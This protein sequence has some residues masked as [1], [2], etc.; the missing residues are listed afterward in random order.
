M[1]TKELTDEQYIALQE[2]LLAYTDAHEHVSPTERMIAMCRLLE[3]ARYGVTSRD[4]ARGYEIDYAEED[5]RIFELRSSLRGHFGVGRGVDNIGTDEPIA[6][7]QRTKWNV[8]GKP[9]AVTEFYRDIERKRQIG[10]AAE[11]HTTASDIQGAGAALLEHGG[12]DT[13]YGAAAGVIT[14]A[15]MDMMLRI[16]SEEAMFKNFVYTMPVQKAAFYFPLKTTKPSDDTSAVGA[17]IDPTAEGRAGLEFAMSFLS[18]YVSCWKHLRHAGL[19]IELLDLLKGYIDLK[20]EY[21]T[22]LAIAHGLLWDYSCAEGMHNMITTAKW[23]RPET[24]G[25]SWSD[26]EYVPLVDVATGAEI[27][28]SGNPE[29]HFLWQDLTPGAGYGLIYNPHDTTPTKY[30]TSDLR[31]GSSAGDDFFE[32]VIALAQLAKNKGSK[33]EYIAI[34]GSMCETWAKDARFLDTTKTTGNP[35]FQNEKG[36]LGQISIGGS[37]Q[38]VDL[39]EYNTALTLAKE[40]TDTTPRAY[41]VIYGGM[42]GKAWAQGILTPFYLRVDDGYEV[43]A[44]GTGGTPSDVIRINETRVITAGSRGTS[45]PLDYHHL[46]LGF[47]VK[48]FA[49]A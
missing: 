8:K 12:I 49:H 21:I 31:S 39:W 29:K 40:S 30:E 5:G 25:P 42:Y 32:L 46:V 41:E 17:A 37:N 16:V 27:I 9:M 18:F 36:Y 19:T 1:F 22:D 48:T 45:F 10:L 6:L 35:A 3:K 26:E 33:L 11:E 38:R 13:G 20:R 44:R 7:Y 15:Y 24:A 23:R 47:I 34:P 4:L 14:P 43:L 2:K 28:G